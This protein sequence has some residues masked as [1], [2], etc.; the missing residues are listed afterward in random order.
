MKKANPIKEWL[1]RAESEYDSPEE[2][3]EEVSRMPNSNTKTLLLDAAGKW[4][5]RIIS[6]RHDGHW[7]KTP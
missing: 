7:S 4:G 5:A 6:K 1:A 2:M 3:R